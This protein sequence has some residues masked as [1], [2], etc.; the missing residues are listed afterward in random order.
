MLNEKKNEKKI[1]TN[2][3]KGKRTKITRLQYQIKK[4]KQ[5]TYVHMKKLK[6]KKIKK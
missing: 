5:H 6:K 1:Y 2:H 3:C 4:K